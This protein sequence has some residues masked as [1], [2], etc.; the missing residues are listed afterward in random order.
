[1]LGVTLDRHDVD[2]LGFVRV[3]VDRKAEIAR[4]IAADFAPRVTRVVAAHHVPV[5]LHEE[6]VGA[7][8]VHG[9]A[10][11]AMADLRVLIGNLSRSQA[12]VDRAPGGAGIVTTKR[13]CRGDRGEDAPRIFWVEQN[14]VQ[15][16][17]AR[18][19]LPGGA[20]RVRAQAGEFTPVL[21]AVIRA[22]E[23]RV[24]DA[25]VHR[26]AIGQRRFEMPHA[27]ELPRM[28]RAVVPLMRAGHAVVDELI[29]DRFP[30]AATVVGALHH[31]T[32][33]T[34]ALRGVE[35]IGIDRR[36]LYVV[37]LPTCKV[38]AAHAPR[39]P[40]AV[41]IENERAFARADQYTYAAHALGIRGLAGTRLA[42]RA[43]IVSP[44]G[45]ASC[46]SRL[47]KRL[48]TSR[49]SKTCRR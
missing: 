17:A 3:H 24:F 18:A 29:A 36:S 5:F 32:R 2:R 37:D 38:R 31:L 23:R 4:Q 40:L 27:R 20:R 43:T 10:M 14:R 46:R 30:G 19:R 16:H 13:A 15:A 42:G 9:D 11:H 48:M 45:E 34:A 33:P 35:P 21:S 6:H 7:R 41:R 25:R 8:G 47:V 39:I 12:A 49:A 1:M 22:K 44:V 26:I 28:R